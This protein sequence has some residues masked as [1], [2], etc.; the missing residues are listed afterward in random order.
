MCVREVKLRQYDSVVFLKQ[1]ER[2]AFKS[3]NL[4]ALLFEVFTL[5]LEEDAPMAKDLLE[6]DVIRTVAL[7]R[8]LGE[9]V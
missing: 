4:A 7:V 3:R 5:E 9:G 6:L 1:G 8:H 2:F